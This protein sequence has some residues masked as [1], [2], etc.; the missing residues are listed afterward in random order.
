M[1]LATCSIYCALSA[2]PKATSPSLARRSSI[3]S[4]RCFQRVSP[5]R[6]LHCSD[7]PH[8]GAL[9]CASR[10]S[11]TRIVPKNP[12]RRLAGSRCAQA[13]WRQLFFTR[14]YGFFRLPTSSRVKLGWTTASGTYASRGAQQSSLHHGLCTGTRH[15]GRTRIALTPIASSKMDGWRPHGPGCLLASGRAFA[16]EAPSRRSRSWSSSGNSLRATASNC[17]DLLHDPS[18]GSP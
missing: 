13:A 15:I 8:A 1:M 4:A 5:P 2:T 18:A 11:A 7:G 6:R 16:S 10:N 17:A 3:K 9:S 14:P 12:L